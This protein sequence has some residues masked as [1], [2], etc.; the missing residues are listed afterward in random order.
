[1]S[2]YADETCALVRIDP[3]SSLVLEGYQHKPDSLRIPNPISGAEERKCVYTGSSSTTNVATVSRSCLI[4][5]EM[6][7]ATR[8]GRKTCTQTS[9][10]ALYR[11]APSTA[12]F[13]GVYKYT[14]MSPNSSL[15]FLLK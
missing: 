3:S 8:F 15:I 13:D 11:A 14:Q 12:S 10:R 5:V 6:L 4:P 2:S 1:M 7:S 9:T